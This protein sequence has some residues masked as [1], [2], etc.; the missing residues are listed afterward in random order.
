MGT[1]EVGFPGDG[2]GPVREVTVDPFSISRL[3][4]TNA[5][6]AAFV[7]VTGHVTGFRVAKNV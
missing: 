7:E 1:D 3:A 6:F 2:E 5:E 4:V